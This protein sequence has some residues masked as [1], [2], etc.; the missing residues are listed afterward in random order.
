MQALTTFLEGVSGYA[1][2][3]LFWLFLLVGMNMVIPLFFLRRLEA[4][5]VL[6][7]FL[8]SFALMLILVDQYEFTPILGLG[9]IFWIPLLVFLGKRLRRT[10]ADTAYG[11]WLRALMVANGVSLVIDATDVARYLANAC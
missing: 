2:L 7:A 3:V 4:R 8:A 1:P 5:V 9:H 10:P 11:L 6:A